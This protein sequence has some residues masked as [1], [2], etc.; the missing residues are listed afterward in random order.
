MVS[1]EEAPQRIVR[2][3]EENTGLSNQRT[4]LAWYRAAISSIAL[5]VGVGKIVPSV[6][7]VSAELWNALGAVFALLA[8]V[9]VIA[10]MRSYRRM[11]LVL[12]AIAEDREHRDEPA[13]DGLFIV[14]IVI[15]L[16]AV[17]CGLLV[18]LGH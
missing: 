16:L 2:L 14:G 17:G 15:V 12:Y 9:L 13:P 18:S 4:L 5:A 11:R 10:G 6:A 7:T 3:N 8:A 1:P